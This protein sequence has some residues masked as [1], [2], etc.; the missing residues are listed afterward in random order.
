MLKK[1]AYEIAKTHINGTSQHMLLEN[2]ALSDKQSEEQI[3]ELAEKLMNCSLK[4]LWDDKN[5]V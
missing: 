3:K 1:Q 5:N 4:N 2:L